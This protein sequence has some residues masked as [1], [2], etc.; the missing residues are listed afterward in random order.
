[1]NS[2]PAL[3]HARTEVI[4]RAIFSS[5]SYFA[6]PPTSTSQVFIGITGMD[7]YVQFIQVILKLRLSLSWGC[8][9]SFKDFILMGFEKK[10]ETGKFSAI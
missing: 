4:F 1:L 9:M 7:Y 3:L 8:F 6:N 5:N 10:I 2:S